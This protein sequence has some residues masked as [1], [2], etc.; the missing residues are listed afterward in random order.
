MKL[1]EIFTFEHLYEAHKKCRLSKQHKGEVIRFEAN[2]SS[3]LV[4]IINEITKR[5]Y[6]LGK[7]KVFKIFEPKERIIEAL[8]YKDRVVIRC[9]CDYSVRS[10]IEKRLIF[11]NVACR[12]GKGTL[13]AIERLEKF[14]RREYL[15]KG[16]NDLYFLKCDIRKFF[17]SINHNILLQ[18]LK[19]IGFSKDEMW[20]ITKLVREQPNNVEMGLPLGN[21]SSQWFALLYLDKVDRLIKEKLRVKSYVRYMDDMILIHR[22]KKYLQK[23]LREIENVCNN[24]L[25][26][27]LNEKTQIGKVCNGIDFLGYRYVLNYRGKIIRK[28]RGSYK[29]RLKRYLKTLGKL[30]ENGVIDDDYVYIRKN[31]FYNHLKDTDESVDL[32]TTVFPKK[33]NNL[34]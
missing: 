32:K 12:K 7:Y 4:N 6:K 14:L 19:N 33:G 10:R 25:S 22:D 16:D 21:Q 1:E 28:L 11:D 3:N 34:N 23:C 17:P 20:F 13:F 8:P 29:V 30:R 26:L 27:S 9:F 18:L 2:L 15:N 24:E 5:K 31:A